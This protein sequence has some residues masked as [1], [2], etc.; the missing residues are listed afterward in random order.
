MLPAPVD[1]ALS[2]LTAAV[3][4]QPDLE[5]RLQTHWRSEHDA[6]AR[7]QA[8]DLPGSVRADVDTLAAGLPELTRSD[9]G[10]AGLL[11]VLRTPSARVLLTW[12]SAS[13]GRRDVRLAKLL[14]AGR[15]AGLGDR[16]ASI[17]R[18]RVV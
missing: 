13:A 10:L 12:C 1:D 8:G 17:V 11:A 15:E 3:E 7:R 4:S 18:D 16:I 6:I 5:T 9:D 14:A 2:R